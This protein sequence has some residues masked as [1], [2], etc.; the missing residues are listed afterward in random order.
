MRTSLVVVIIILVECVTLFAMLAPAVPETAE[1]P[2]YSDT[3]TQPVFVVH[4]YG[5]I[6]FHFSGVG[7]VYGACGGFQMVTSASKSPWYCYH[8]QS[9]LSQS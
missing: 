5:S 8:F 1:E 7:V 9:P 4:Y 2:C 6:S 3:C